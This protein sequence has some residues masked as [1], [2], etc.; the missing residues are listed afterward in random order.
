MIRRA[1]I[2]AACILASG[3]AACTTG[4]AFAR[5]AYDVANPQEIG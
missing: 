3:V 2:L 1:L 4:N 5:A